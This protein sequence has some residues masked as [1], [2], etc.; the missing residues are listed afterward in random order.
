M[1]CGMRS[2]RHPAGERLERRTEQ[3]HGDVCTPSRRAGPFP[4]G[5]GELLKDFNR[6]DSLISALG[7]STWG[8]L[9]GVSGRRRPESR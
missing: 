2:K 3:E 1:Q 6:C 7:R 9:E 4:E 8:E 5:I